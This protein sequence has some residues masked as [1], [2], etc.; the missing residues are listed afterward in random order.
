[1]SDAGEGLVDAEAR[2]QEQMDAREH[3]KRRR[4]AGEVADPEKHRARESLKLMR[5]DL[6][7]QFEL[8]THAARRESISAAMKEIDRKLAAL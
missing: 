6:A 8:T 1:M 5:A 7:R 4:T 3:E 2:L